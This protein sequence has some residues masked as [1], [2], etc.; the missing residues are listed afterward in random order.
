MTRHKH[1]LHLASKHIVGELHGL[2]KALLG[3]STREETVGWLAAALNGNK[4]RGKMQENL[5]VRFCFFCNRMGR[6]CGL[7]CLYS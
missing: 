5:A 6:V 7:C 2:V 1:T 3:K 4:E